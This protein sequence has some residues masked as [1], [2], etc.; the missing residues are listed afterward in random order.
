M[1]V[2][3]T[4]KCSKPEFNLCIPLNTLVSYKTHKNSSKSRA[5]RCTEADC[6]TVT[7]ISRDFKT[8][9][10]R[11]HCSS[12]H[13]KSSHSPPFSPIVSL[14]QPPSPPLAPHSARVSLYVSNSGPLSRSLLIPITLNSLFSALRTVS[15]YFL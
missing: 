12:K 4:D 1:L 6:H 5:A 8:C 9:Q 3:G 15:T 14:S 10:S 13:I 11:L 7:A 2:Y